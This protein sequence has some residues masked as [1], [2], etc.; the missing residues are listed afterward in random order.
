M[1][2]DDKMIVRN[3]CRELN[4]QGYS[5]KEIQ[6]QLKQDT[7]KTYSLDTIRQYLQVRMDIKKD[8]DYMAHC[9]IYMGSCSHPRVEEEV[10]SFDLAMRGIS[11]NEC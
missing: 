4:K 10:D 9:G 2:K 11:V 5:R 1:A 7:D 6:T 3:R 8:N